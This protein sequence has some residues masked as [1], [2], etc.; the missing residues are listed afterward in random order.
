MWPQLLP[1]GCYVNL[2]LRKQTL[3]PYLTR[4]RSSVDLMYMVRYMYKRR[5]SRQQRLP[6][7]LSCF[8]SKTFTCWRRN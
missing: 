8:S 3:Q 7:H 4:A 1:L 2:V 5:L 6:Q